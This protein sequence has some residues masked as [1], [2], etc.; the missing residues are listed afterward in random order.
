M[1]ACRKRLAAFA[2]VILAF[3]VAITA[4]PAFASRYPDVPDNH[5][6][7]ISGVIDRAADEGI[8]KGYDDG[9]FGPDDSVTRAQVAVMLARIAKADVG[10][11][12]NYPAN[13]TGFPDVVDHAWYTGAVNW[14]VAN[15]IFNGS[16]GMMMPDAPITREQLAAVLSNYHKKQGG[17]IASD[18]D[19]LLKYSDASS[20]SAWAKD[21]V[22]WAVE[23]GI[24]GGGPVI[25]PIGGATRAETAKMILVFNDGGDKQPTLLKSSFIDVGQGD[26]AFIQLPNGQTMLIDAGPASRASNVVNTLRQRGVT[27]L[28]YV[29]MTH[30]DADHIGGMQTVIKN[31]SIGK[32]YAPNATSTTQTWMNLLQT[33]ADKG[34][35]INEARAGVTVVSESGLSVRFLAPVGTGETTNE[36]SAITLIDYGGKTLLYTGDAEAADI[37][38]VT[39]GHVD[40]LKVSH[41]GSNTGTS[42]AL[43]NKLTPTNAVISVGRGNS[44]GHPTRTVLDLLRGANMYRTD[45]SGTVI[46]MTDT[47]AVW[48]NV[49]AS[50]SIPDP[51]P[52]PTPDPTPD[53]TPNP[54]PTPDP[55]PNPDPAPNPGPDLNTTVWVTKTGKKYHYDWCST[56]Q[57]SKG[58]RSMSAAQA[59]SSGYTACKVCNPPQ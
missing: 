1:Q 37:T 12:G 41:H 33:I 2:A 28:D 56:I 39:P 46:G 52:T 50:Q 15:G 6:A 5:W 7:Q 40:V 59:K 21:A 27:H 58:L 19:R 25:N 11:D 16:N 4:T 42:Q 10:Q 47:K 23:D 20:V 18:A 31:F 36:S 44:Y 55:K 51:T 30:P 14:A 13:T 43:V 8:V 24:M 45:Y 29:V 38:A 34:L 22:S 53:P 26:A 17:T 57:K 35:V 32:L 49:P 48:F 9:R 54:E 3:A